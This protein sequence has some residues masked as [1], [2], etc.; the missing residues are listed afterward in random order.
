MLQQGL[1]QLRAHRLDVRVREQ[2]QPRGCG[3]GGRLHVGL[4]DTQRH[5]DLR[6]AESIWNVLC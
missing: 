1:V 6:K 4:E 2:Q 5:G 3:P